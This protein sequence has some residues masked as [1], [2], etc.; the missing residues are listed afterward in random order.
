MDLNVKAL[1]QIWESRGQDA[2]IREKIVLR[3]GGRTSLDLRNEARGRIP[4]AVFTLK[5]LNELYMW[6]CDIKVFPKTLCCRLKNLS[7]LNLSRNKIP[8]IPRSITELKNLEDLDL[9]H[10]LITEIPQE[11]GK[12]QKLS[13]LHLNFNFILELPEEICDC[14]HL[15]IFNVMSNQIAK[16]PKQLHNLTSLIEFDLSKNKLSGTLECSVGKLSA[17]E[18]LDISHNQILEL[19]SE[20][21]NLVQ[22]RS[23]YLQNN[24]VTSLT[25]R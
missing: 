1:R 4:K 7:V 13:L 15:K 11:I 5:D 19:P 16:L 3:E 10:N 9:S 2:W 14:K 25:T 17:L 18:W 22:L 23:L 6:R 12:L 8:A 24:I 21:G 20:I